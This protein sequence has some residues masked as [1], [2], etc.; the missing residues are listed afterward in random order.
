MYFKYE[1]G[2]FYTSGTQKDGYKIVIMTE[3]PVTPGGKEALFYWREE[4]NS[5]VQTWE[6][7]DENNE[8]TEEELAEAGRILMGYGESN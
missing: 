3:K 4:E 1:N 2:L 5:F 6:I 7:V 8:E